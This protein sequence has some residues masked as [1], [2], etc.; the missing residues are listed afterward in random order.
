MSSQYSDVV[1]FT[2]YWQAGDSNSMQV[3][4]SH[5]SDTVHVKVT[6]GKNRQCAYT[7]KEF[8]VEEGRND[9]YSIEE[10]VAL[11][12]CLKQALWMERCQEDKE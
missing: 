12:K 4:N 9:Y 2:P 7:G 11:Y 3:I 5:T 10:A 1:Q 6:Y 8:P